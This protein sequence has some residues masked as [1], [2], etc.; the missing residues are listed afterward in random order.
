MTEHTQNAVF[1]LLAI[2]HISSLFYF[3]ITI[4]I[5]K[6][7]KHVLSNS[8]NELPNTTLGLQGFFMVREKSKYKL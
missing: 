6:S 5:F 4:K 2:L 1:Y 8:P 3:H 7:K